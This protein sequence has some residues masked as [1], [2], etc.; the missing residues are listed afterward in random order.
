MPEA[1]IPALIAP[2]INEPTNVP[3]TVPIP[4]NTEVPPRNT[5]AIEF[6][7]KPS[8]NVGQKYETS[9]DAT[10]PANAAKKPMIANV[11][12]LTWFTFTPIN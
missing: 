3:V 6:I 1:T 9:N 4:P 5:P 8:P 2:I 12:R 10:R 7:N 11:L